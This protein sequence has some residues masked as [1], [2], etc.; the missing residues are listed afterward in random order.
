LSR[1]LAQGEAARFPTEHLVLNFPGSRHVTIAIGHGVSSEWQTVVGESFANTVIITQ[2][3]IPL[4]SALSEG[5]SVIEIAQG[6]QAKTLVEVERVAV[7]LVELGVTRKDLLVAVGGGTVTD[8]TG[9]VA[10]IYHRGLSYLN[11]PTTLL[12][13]VDAAIGGKTGVNLPL[14]KNLLGTFY[15]PTGIIV[16]LDLLASLPEQEWLSGRG[17]MVKYEFL[18]IAG[19]GRMSLPE[20]VLQCVRYKAA[21]VTVDER[22]SSERERLNYGHSIGHALEALSLKRGYSDR[23]SHGVAVAKG[24]YV[25]SLLA[26]RLGRIGLEG[27]KRHRL[28][29]EKW[30]FDLSA[31]SWCRAHEV[32]SAMGRDKKNFGNFRVA[33]DGPNGVEVVGGVPVDEILSTVA[34]WIAEGKR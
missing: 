8:F 21:V 4:P 3:G 11:V 1:S 19:L 31:P 9:F 12:A 22:D 18:G 14:G 16:D 7:R 34:Q 13:M 5:V 25:E 23:L 32:V 29:L 6:E 10:S 24:L 27:V 26:M 17:E 20:Q 33:L 30:G 28:T 15:Q 2:R